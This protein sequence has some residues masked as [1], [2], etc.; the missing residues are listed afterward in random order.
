VGQS[1]VKLQLVGGSPKVTGV[2]LSVILQND[3]DTPLILPHSVHAIIRYNGKR[4]DAEVKAVFA[5]S[6]VAP[7]SS[8]PGTVHVPYDKADPTADLI[9]PQLLPPTFAQRDVHLITSLAAR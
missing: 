6:A 1:G 7:H 3:G 2:E 4:P 5:S 8:V 9:L